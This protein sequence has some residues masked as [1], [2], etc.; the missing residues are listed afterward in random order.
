[1][2][3]DSLRDQLVRNQSSYSQMMM[4]MIRV[5]NHLRNRKIHLPDSDPQLEPRNSPLFRLSLQA[6]HVEKSIIDW[7][8]ALILAICHVYV[9]IYIYTYICC[10][11]W[12]YSPYSLRACPLI[13]TGNQ[14]LSPIWGKDHTW[15]V[16][17]LQLVSA[18]CPY[19][20]AYTGFS[21][22]MA[23]SKSPE[24]K[25][26]NILRRFFFEKNGAVFFFRRRFSSA[27]VS[28]CTRL[29]NSVEVRPTKLSSF[30]WNWKFESSLCWIEVFSFNVHAGFWLA[31][32]CPSLET[33]KF[34][35]HVLFISK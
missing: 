24:D 7:D 21:V 4:M 22:S 10:F 11:V 23:T 18:C 28:W 12:V 27:M 1:M 6:A 26:F 16:Q 29:E 20:M 3:I 30:S 33:L 25:G 32:L 19:S 15:K 31:K 13:P 35:K 17:E 2:L 8:Q 9:D 5:S 14:Q 34:L